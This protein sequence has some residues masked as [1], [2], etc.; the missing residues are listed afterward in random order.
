MSFFESTPS[1]NLLNRFAKEIDAIDCMIPDG[2]KMMLGYVFKLMEV[3]IIVLLATPFS[4]VIILPLALLYAFVQVSRNRL[5]C[6]ITMG[7]IWFFWLGF[8]LFLSLSLAHWRVSTWPHHA[9]LGVWSPWAALPF[10]PTLTRQCKVPVWS[11]PLVSN[12]ASFCRPIRGWITT[13]L[14][15]SPDLWQPGKT[16]CCT[17]VVPYIIRHLTIWL[18]GKYDHQG[19]ICNYYVRLLIFLYLMVRG[20][21]MGK[22]QA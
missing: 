14:P 22:V 5:R 16:P 17:R 10:T 12:H 2:L 18:L 21:L 1:G 19:G 15:T 7:N 6:S 4:A 9:S 20:C 13:K 11:G 8:D 3:C